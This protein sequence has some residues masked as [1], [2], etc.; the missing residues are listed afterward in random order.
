MIAVQLYLHER[1]CEELGKHGHRFVEQIDEN[2]SLWVTPWDFHFTVP[3]I[4]PDKACAK[5]KLYEI[6]ADIEKQKPQMQ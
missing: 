1:V 5:S 6:L 3:T 2:T 4:G